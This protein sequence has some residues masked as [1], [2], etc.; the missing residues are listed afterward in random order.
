M[1]NA[2]RHIV[3]FGATGRQ[4]GSVARALLQAKWPVRALVRDP[5]GPKSTALRDAGVEL[6]QG[7]F[8]DI[9]L[10]RAVMKNAHG[11]FSMLPS[12]LAEE[13][14]VRFGTAIADLAVH[15]L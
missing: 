1:R 12:N 5:T 9:D 6:V 10:I 8:A 2:Q 3:I 14:E 4:G 11:V 15:R 13:E 7:S